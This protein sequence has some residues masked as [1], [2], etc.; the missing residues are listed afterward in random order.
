MFAAVF[1]E[2][3]TGNRAAAL[4]AW[5]DVSELTRLLFAEPSPAPAKHWLARTGLIAS[6]EVRLP[7][8]EVSA[9]LASRLDREIAMR[10]RPEARLVNAG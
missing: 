6:A 1:A 7:M 4:A 5:Q 3:K 8:M 2:M 10:V 9:E